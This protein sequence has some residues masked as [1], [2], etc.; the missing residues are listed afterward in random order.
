M[1]HIIAGHGRVVAFKHVRS[2][3]LTRIGELTGSDHEPIARHAEGD[4]VIREA[5]VEFGVLL[6]RIGMPALD[7]VV[8]GHL[9]VPV[10]QVIQVFRVVPHA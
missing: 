1:H 10:G 4:F 2:E 6:E 9:R 8:N 3:D 7:V 5:V